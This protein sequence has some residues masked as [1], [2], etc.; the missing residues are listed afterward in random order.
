MLGVHFTLGDG[1]LDG[2][3]RLALVRAVGEAAIARQRPDVG[4]LSAMP[5]LTSSMPSSRMPGMSISWHRP[6][7]G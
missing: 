3:T 1:A 5:S 7:T 2:A 6:A 4:K